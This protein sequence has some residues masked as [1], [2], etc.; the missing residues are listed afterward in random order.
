MYT[1]QTVYYSN[2]NMTAISRNF[3]AKACFVL[4]GIVTQIAAQSAATTF[5]WQPLLTVQVQSPQAGDTVTGNGWL[6]DIN[7]DVLSPINNTLISATAG[8]SSSYNNAT[9]VA[10]P[11]L[12]V[13]LST[14]STANNCSGPWVSQQPR[15]MMH[16]VLLYCC[17]CRMI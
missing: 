14:M 1:I 17:Y 5:P 7:V 13:L 11:G 6:I 9:A 12:V 10:A 3:F 16:P 2:G 8:Y 4:I 15:I